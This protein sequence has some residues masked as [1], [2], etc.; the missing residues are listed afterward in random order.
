M[1]EERVS[2]AEFNSW[3]VGGE[4]DCLARPSGMEE[5]REILAWAKETNQKVSVLGG[6]TNVLVSDRGVRGLVIHMRSFSGI[7]EKI[8]NH[9]LHLECLSGTP[10]AFGFEIIFKTQIRTCRFFNRTA[11][12]HWWG[13]GDE[14]R[15]GW[16]ACSQRILRNG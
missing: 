4:A 9:R 10:K 6:G 16:V 15:C 5:L 12:R 14:R 3:G 8:E 2:L 7:E 1:K 13:C 11:W